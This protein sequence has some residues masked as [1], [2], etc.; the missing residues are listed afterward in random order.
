MQWLKVMPG[1][2]VGLNEDPGTLRRWMISGPEVGRL[3][4][5]FEASLTTEAQV[6]GWGWEGAMS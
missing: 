1:G 5:D 4:N 2:A 3:I 6:Q